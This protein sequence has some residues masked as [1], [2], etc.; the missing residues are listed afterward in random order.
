MFVIDWYKDEQTEQKMYKLQEYC[1]QFAMFMVRLL[2][3]TQEYLSEE[4]EN[5]I[6]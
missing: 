2:D 6:K 5:N 3:E 1:E 4:I